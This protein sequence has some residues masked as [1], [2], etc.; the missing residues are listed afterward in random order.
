[1]VKLG[2]QDHSSFTGKERDEE[3]GYGYFGARYMDHE[4]MTMWLSVDPLDDKYPGISPYN[5][6]AWNPVK[7]VDPDGCDTL[8]FSSKGYYQK[9]N[10]GGKNIGI[11]IGTNGNVSKEFVFAD[12]HW[13]DLFV[14]MRDTDLE[15]ENSVRHAEGKEKLYNRIKIISDEYIQKELKRSGVNIIKYLPSLVKLA[16][17]YGESRHGGIG[18]LDFVNNINKSESSGQL[19]VTTVN[20]ISIAHDHFNFGNF[21]WG[22]AMRWLGIEYNI[23]FLGSNVDNMIHNQ[24]EMDSIDDQISIMHG[25]SYE[26]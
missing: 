24:G 19:F 6:C 15:W 18:R 16:Y 25:Y 5:Y 9:T 20:G 13:C 11:I 1:M 21:L 22:A 8:L 14:N 12:D 3:T 26:Y 7:L 10:K 2:I 4:L 23:V 17:V